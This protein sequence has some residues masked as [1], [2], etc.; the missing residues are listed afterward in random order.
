MYMFLSMVTKENLCGTCVFTASVCVCLCVCVYVFVC[1][2]VCVCAYVCIVCVC[3]RCLHILLFAIA[4][5]LTICDWTCKNQPSEHL[6]ITLFSTLLYQL[7]KITQL[8]NK[9]FIINADF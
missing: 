6:K 5:Y 8:N 2:C 3:G 9:L 1:V 4:S 7:L